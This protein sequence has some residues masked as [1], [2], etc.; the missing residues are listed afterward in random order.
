MF[1]ANVLCFNM[2]KTLTAAAK[3][4]KNHD[5]FFRMPKAVPVFKTCDIDTSG[6][7]IEVFRGIYL[8]TKNF[9]NLSR[10]KTNTA[11]LQNFRYLL[12]IFADT[13]YFRRA[14]ISQDAAKLFLIVL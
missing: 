4:I 14:P 10:R 2:R 8:V 1:S 3:T 9:V 7:S 12:A 13:D 6:K 5:A 11:M